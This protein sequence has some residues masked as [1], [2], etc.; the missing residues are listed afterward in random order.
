MRWERRRSSHIDDEVASK[1]YETSQAVSEIEVVPIVVT[2]EKTLDGRSERE[3][4]GVSK[5]RKAG[6]YENTY[7]IKEKEI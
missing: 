5:L 7:V 2:R 4:R 3:H 1:L 6:R